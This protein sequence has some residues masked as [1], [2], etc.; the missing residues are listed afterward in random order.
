[1]SRERACTL[2]PDSVSSKGALVCLYACTRICFAERDIQAGE[3]ICISYGNLSDAQLLRIFGFV[4]DCEPEVA[5][6]Q[7]SSAQTAYVDNPH[8]DVC[9]PTSVLHDAF[10]VGLGFFASSAT[11]LWSYH[12]SRGIMQRSRDGSHVIRHTSGGTF[13][14]IFLHC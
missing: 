14:A 4:A 8:N 10:L 7:S 6:D 11:C 5:T 1:M 12:V 13:A 3:E 9:L 2:C